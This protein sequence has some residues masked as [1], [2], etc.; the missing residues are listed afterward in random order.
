M[1]FDCFPPS[2]LQ[3]G[4]ARTLNPCR[5]RTLKLLPTYLAEVPAMELK[6]NGVAMARVP[7][8]EVEAAFAEHQ[9]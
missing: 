2:D 6:Q 1:S 3:E 5:G 8:I 9:N 7:F 4:D